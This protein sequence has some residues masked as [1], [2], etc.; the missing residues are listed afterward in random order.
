[1]YV[2]TY[3]TFLSEFERNRPRMLIA[4]TRNPLSDWMSIIVRTVSYR[5][6]WPTFLVES[7]FV[8][9]CREL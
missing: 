6:E 5:I 7:V 2:C 8:A 1:M 4:K 9:T 3:R